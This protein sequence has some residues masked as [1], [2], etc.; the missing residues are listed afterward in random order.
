MY[1][2]CGCGQLVE[3]K[4]GGHR[5]RMFVDDAHKMKYWRQQRQAA[6]H[7]ALLTELE[8]LRVKVT[9]Q[10]QQI[11]EQEAEIARLHQALDIEKRYLEDT[12]PR[13]FKAW[14][15]KTQPSSPWRNT[16][17]S[18][19]LVPARGSRAMYEAHVRR[20]H[21]S[22]EEHQDFVRLWKLLLLQS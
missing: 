6:Q 14:L 9:D 4:P 2:K 20:L 8:E 5:Q 16:F 10:A 3:E 19:Q 13:P 17:L 1:C 18:D 21:C 7:T 11:E 15:R 22:D 12:T